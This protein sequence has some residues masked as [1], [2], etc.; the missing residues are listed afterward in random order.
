MGVGAER[1]RH[2]KEQPRLSRPCL[3]SV[4]NQLRAEQSQHEKQCVTPGVL[5]EPDMMRRNGRQHRARQRLEPR[6]DPSTH[7]VDERDRRDPEQDGREAE[8][9]RRFTAQPDADVRKH[10]IEHMSVVGR[11]VRDGEGK[12]LADRVHEGDDLIVP[13]LITAPD[14][15]ERRSDDHRQRQQRHRSSPPEVRTISRRCRSFASATSF[16]PSGFPAP[17]AAEHRIC[18]VRAWLK[19]ERRGKLND[20]CQLPP[21]AP[22]WHTVDR[23]HIIGYSRVS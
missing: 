3:Q 2:R 19:F 22:G 1:A 16:A 6:R 10:G 12:R 17:A 7:G 21:I 11:E 15:S 18:L 23:P 20:T 14:K 5:R 8:H 4:E 13:E 9:G